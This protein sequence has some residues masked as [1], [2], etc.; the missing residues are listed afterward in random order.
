[1]GDNLHHLLASTFGR[2]PAFYML[3]A[4]GAM[5]P[6]VWLPDLKALSYLGFL[7]VSA[8]AAVTLTVRW[9]PS[10]SLNPE[11]ANYFSR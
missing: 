1:M 2:T 4:A 7:G 10:S 3:V 8:T 6:T 5:I 11:R 9:L